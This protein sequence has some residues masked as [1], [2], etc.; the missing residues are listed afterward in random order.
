VAV[1]VA[2]LAGLARLQE[3]VLEMHWQQ[4]QVVAVG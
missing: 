4:W 3:Q 1:V 2:R